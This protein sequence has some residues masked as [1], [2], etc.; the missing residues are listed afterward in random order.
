MLLGTVFAEG[1]D[2]PEVEVVINAE[3]GRDAKATMQRM[4]NMTV[5]EGKNRALLIDFMDEFNPYLQKHSMERLK[6]YRS[7]PEFNVEVIG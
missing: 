7:I 4:R 1:V 2:I 5:A 3:G 6:V